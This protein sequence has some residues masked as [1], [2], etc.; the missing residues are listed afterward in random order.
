MTKTR[1]DWWSYSSWKLNA[2]LRWSLNSE[3]KPNNKLI[4]K[5]ETDQ[6]R[7]FSLKVIIFHVRA[8]YYSSLVCPTRCLG[9]LCSFAIRN[10][11]IKKTGHSKLRS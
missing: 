2:E 6:E 8:L 9:L 10:Y 4:I 7:Y 3:S 11:N 5:N 1:N